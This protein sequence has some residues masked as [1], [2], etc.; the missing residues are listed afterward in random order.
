[1]TVRMGYAGWRSSARTSLGT[2][3]P[4]V[5]SVPR[6]G[7][8]RGESPGQERHSGKTALKKHRQK[9]IH[10]KSA[11]KLKILYCYQHPRVLHRTAY[12]VQ[13][14]VWIFAVLLDFT[15]TNKT[16][17]WVCEQGIT[18][19]NSSLKLSFTKTML[20]SKWSLSRNR[21]CSP[22]SQQNRRSFL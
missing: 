18:S 21:F 8:R 4:E 1:M 15:Q 10:V 14:S 12:T 17:K 20:C 2:I 7:I 22:Q 9:S 6:P 19:K 5:A 13:R 16:G 3:C 11:N